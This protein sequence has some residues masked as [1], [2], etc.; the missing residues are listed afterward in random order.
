MSFCLCCTTFLFIK[1]LLSISLS[2]TH[3]YTNKQV[4]GISNVELIDPVQMAAIFNRLENIKLWLKRYPDWD[5]NKQN[6]VLGGFTLATGVFM[7]P[8]RAELTRYLIEEKGAD[9]SLKTFAGSNTLHSIASG[10][11]CCPESLKIILRH[12]KSKNLS[13]DERRY[14]VNFK[15]KTIVRL[16]KLYYQYHSSPS[17]IAKLLGVDS[18]GTALHS[19]VLRGDLE[20]VEIL[21]SAGA[22]P[23]IKNDLDM[24]AVSMSWNFPALRGLLQKRHRALRFGRGMAQDTLVPENNVVLGKRISTATT[25]QHDMWLIS[26]STLLK[27]Y[28][29]D[30]KRELMEPHQHLLQRGDLIRWVNVPSDA[31]IV[32]VS[33]EWLS[34]AHP[35]P[36][37]K[38]LKTLCRVLERLRDGDID[39]VDMSALHTIQYKHNFTVL[40]NDWKDMLRRTFLWV[41]WFSMPQ[42]S[43]EKVED[44]GDAKMEELRARGSRAIR[45]IPAYVERSDFMMILAPPSE[46]KNRGDD[47]NTCY[48]TWRRRG[49]CL[50]ELFASFMSRDVTNP[51]LLVRSERGTPTWVSPSDASNMC[52]GQAKFTCCER[53][54]AITTETQKVINDIF[55]K[56]D[57]EEEK[58]EV[59]MTIPCDKPIAGNIMQRL[60]EAKVSHM[61]NTNGDVRMARLFES[62]S[63]WWLRDLDDGWITQK[64]KAK[65]AKEEAKKRR[66]KEARELKLKEEKKRREYRRNMYASKGQ[67]MPEEERKKDEELKEKEKKM[68]EEEKTKKAEE[69]AKEPEMSDE[70][71]KAR[72]ERDKASL[73]DF[74]ERRMRW[75]TKRK[76]TKWFDRHGV[77]IL[78]YAVLTNDL[79]VVRELLQELREEFPG[80]K[81]VDEYVFFFLCVCVCHSV[82]H[83]THRQ[84]H[85]PTHATHTHTHTTIQVQ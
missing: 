35:D 24:D 77:G 45:S 15:W 7:G 59:E 48:R 26:M 18:G 76:D 11:D 64:I 85:S 42:P 75:D 27:L 20:I 83:I 19:A 63:T 40:S 33:H 78:L 55:S 54:H 23:T 73:Q 31:E 61:F 13:V 82:P 17:M 47:D 14:P 28:G 10:T 68:K 22:D 39:R 80:G 72:R 3:T 49:W 43:A 74:K 71:K 69:D 29:K 8:N 46:H 57:E 37:G 32:F 53:N 50:L 44:I 84:Y 38:K 25:L 34:Y 67:K 5:L 30:G 58:N 66:E 36:E 2:H 4:K 60:I 41:D 9:L 70:E 1:C 62:M 51:P 81:T 6:R 65:Q 16:S 79:P 12:M 52:V 21:L 56:E